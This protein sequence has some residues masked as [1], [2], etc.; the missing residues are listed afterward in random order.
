M[1]KIFVKSMILIV[2]IFSVTGC[3]QIGEA[4]GCFIF[5]NKNC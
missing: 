5:P 4:G 1:K 2:M 3:E